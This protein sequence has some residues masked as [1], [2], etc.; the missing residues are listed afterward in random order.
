M[1]DKLEWYDEKLRRWLRCE[2]F[3]WVGE[4]C[5]GKMA[6]GW[7]NVHK[8]YASVKDIKKS[9]ADG[10]IVETAGSSET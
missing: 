2:E 8:L 9:E 10:R 3:C 6:S 1:S 7:L 4:T 5:Y